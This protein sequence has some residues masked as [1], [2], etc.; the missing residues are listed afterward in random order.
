MVSTHTPIIDPLRT[1][2][3]RVFNSAEQK[4]VSLAQTALFYIGL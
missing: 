3:L 2:S 1:Q 4:S